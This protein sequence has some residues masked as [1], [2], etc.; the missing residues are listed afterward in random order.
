MSWGGFIEKGGPKKGGTLA[1]PCRFLARNCSE[2]PR[3]PSDRDK[4]QESPRQ[5]KPKKGQ[6][7][8]IHEFAHFCVNSGVFPWENKR[9]SHRTFVPE[10]PRE[11]FMNWPFF[12]LVCRVTP[13]AKRPRQD[14][15]DWFYCA[16]AW[17]GPAKL[18]IHRLSLRINRRE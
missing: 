13:E 7:R 5:A 15:D 16:W 2:T 12:G 18:G 9:D 8:E 6:K 4:S 10:C 1:S 14:V 17:C 11:K 3:S